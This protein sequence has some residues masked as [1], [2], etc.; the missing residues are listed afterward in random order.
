[1]NGLFTFSSEQLSQL[2]E[3]LDNNRRAQ[4][5]S[6]CRRK[7]MHHKLAKK[8]LMLALEGNT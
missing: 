5:E 7:I 6:S 4:Q 8:S 3:N 2:K 1:M